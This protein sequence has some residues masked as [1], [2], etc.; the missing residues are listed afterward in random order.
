MDSR[1]ITTAIAVLVVLCCVQA[2]AGADAADDP[3]FDITDGTGETFHF[4]GASEHIVTSGFATTV[5]VADAGAIDKLVAVD[6]FSTYE[7]THDERLRGLDAIDLGSFYATTNDDYIVTTL[8]K[9]VQD[10]RMN[11]DDAII[12]TSYSDNQSLKDA[13]TQYGFTHVLMWVTIDT[14]GELISMVRD[15]SMIATGTTP[16]SIQD[17]QAKY[18]AVREGV[19]DVTERSKALYIWYYNNSYTIGNTGIMTSM[20]KACNADDVGHDPDNSSSRYGDKNLIISIL[21]DNPG[22]I[23]FVS[24]NYF[25]SGNTLDDLYDDLFGGDRTF[26]VV[27]MGQDWNNWCPESSDGLYSIAQC[28]YPEVFGEYTGEMGGGETGDGNGGVD[29]VLIVAAVIVI[30]IV[31]GA[32]AYAM[33]RRK[34]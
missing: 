13:L 4:D 19:S 3:G 28:L 23:V 20:L 17:M 12:L 15:V 7:Y 18:D 14:Y 27:P 2:F 8:V 33:K 11:L 26:T 24:H 31:I 22:T 1:I 9:L 10:G 25:S 5:T 16:Q 29:A 32:V 34:P 6:K 21:E 30:V